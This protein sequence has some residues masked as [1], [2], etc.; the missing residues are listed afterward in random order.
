MALEA[1]TVCVLNVDGGIA[2]EAL[3][4]GNVPEG[5]ALEPAAVEV[6]WAEDAAGG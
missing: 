6:G 2:E 5:A 3:D 4:A 1:G